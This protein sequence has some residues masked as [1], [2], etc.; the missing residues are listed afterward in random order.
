MHL[1]LEG[2]KLNRRTVLAGIGAA[3][4]LGVSWRAGVASQDGQTFEIMKTE[5]EWR[6]I[7]NAEQFAVLRE[8]A[9]E[10]PFTSTLLEEKREGIYACAACDLPLYS[11]ETKFD[12]KT[13]WPSFY[14]AL[15]QAIGTKEDNTLFTTRTECHCRRCGGHLGH[16]FNDGPPPTG[17]R[18][19]INGVAMSFKPADTTGQG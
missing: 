13:G 5:E 15:P 8:E 9:T 3:G 1:V 14:E 11:S 10:R 2:R 7:L 12:S 18:H 6:E 19:C 4:L 16:I 17:K